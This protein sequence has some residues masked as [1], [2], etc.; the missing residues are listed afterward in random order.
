MVNYALYV[1]F[2]CPKQKSEKAALRQK[3]VQREMRTLTTKRGGSRMT[4]CGRVIEIFNHP[5]KNDNND[6]QIRIVIE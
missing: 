1:K 4:V 3:C 6:S 5:N 2:A